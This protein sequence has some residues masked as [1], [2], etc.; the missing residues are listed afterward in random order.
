MPIN[1][2]VNSDRTFGPEFT[3]RY[4]MYRCSQINAA[5][6]PGYSTGQA[7]KALEEIFA[8]TMPNGM[9]FDYLGMSSRSRKPRR[10]CHRAPF[11]AFLC[12]LSF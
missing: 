9:G 3:M 4:N 11:S 7:M 6:V 5:V 2:F 12:S 10:A 8:Q 1:S